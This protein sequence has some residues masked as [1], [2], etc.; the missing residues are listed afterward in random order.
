MYYNFPLFTDERKGTEKVSALLQITQPLRWH[1]NSDNL[2]E[3]GYLT[4][5][6]R[7]LLDQW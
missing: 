5:C 1:F 4:I 3:M 6:V 7:L 2:I